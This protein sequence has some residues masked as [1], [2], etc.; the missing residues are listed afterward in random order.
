METEPAGTGTAGDGDR[1]GTEQGQSRDGAER[2]NDFAQ[3]FS[4]TCILA[5]MQ[6]N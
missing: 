6:A 1:A 5:R 2:F 4:V 3:L